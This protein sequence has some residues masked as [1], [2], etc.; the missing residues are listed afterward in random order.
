MFYTAQVKYLNGWVT[1]DMTY[2]RSHAESVLAKYARDG[3]RTRILEE[4]LY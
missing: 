4:K 1:V 3:Y 2:Y